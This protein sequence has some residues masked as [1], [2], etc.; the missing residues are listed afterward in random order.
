MN[1]INSVCV[2][3]GSSYGDNPAFKEQA[4]FL[5]RYIADRKID[6]VFGGG[7][8]G[9]MGEVSKACLD[10]GGSVLGIIPERIFDMVT[11]DKRCETRVVKDMH[12]R[13]SMMYDCSDAFIALPGGIGTAEEFFE[14]FTWVQLGYHEKPVALYNMENYFDSL[15]SFIDT[16]V[17][18]KFM[19]DVHR[20]KLVVESDAESLFTSMKAV[21]VSFVKKIN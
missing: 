7:D 16:M 18:R 12:E 14:V 2:F 17:E 13:K 6:L 15:I 19:K 4:A 21:D 10:A 5:G 11:V 20:N 9:L 8:V 3:C 1:V